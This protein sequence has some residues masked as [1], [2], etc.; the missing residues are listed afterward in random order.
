M[1]EGRVMDLFGIVVFLHFGKILDT[2]WSPHRWTDEVQIKQLDSDIDWQFA[3][4]PDSDYCH[5]LSWRLITSGMPQGLI[6]QPKL[7]DIHW[8]P[9]WWSIIRNC[10]YLSAQLWWDTLGVLCPVLG[11]HWS[12]S[13]ERS[14]GWLGIGAYALWEEA[15]ETWA[16][17]PGEDSEASYP[18]E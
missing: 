5:K 7:Q 11:T 17:Q 16:V 8:W 15:E 4:L 10:C 12:Q 2:V 9:G 18:C 14:W 1:N 13:R 3:K 6:L